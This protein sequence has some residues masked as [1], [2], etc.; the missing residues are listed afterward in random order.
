MKGPVKV[1]GVQPLPRSRA[2]TDSWLLGVPDLLGL[3]RGPW[4]RTH[5]HGV[6]RFRGSRGHGV[7]GAR[8]HRGLVIQG[9]LGTWCL[10]GGQ[11]YQGYQTIRGSNISVG[12]QWY[13]NIRGYQCGIPE[14]SELH[15]VQRYHGVGYQRY[16]ISRGPRPSTYNVLLM[17]TN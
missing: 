11:G 17:S 6:Q 8:P 1:A 15:R 16:Q 3:H 7:P 10:D 12:Y 13:Q 14:V 2:T 5:Q 4:G 9:Y